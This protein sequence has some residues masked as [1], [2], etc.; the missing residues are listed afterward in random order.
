MKVKIRKIGNSLG[1]LLPK[2]TLTLLGLKDG[3]ELELEPKNKQIELV[4][5]K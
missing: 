2:D 3:D 5:R 1:I 4:L